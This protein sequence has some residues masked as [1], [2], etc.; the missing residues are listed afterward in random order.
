[1][2]R[3]TLLASTLALLI[4]GSATFAIAQDTNAPPPAGT[5]AGPGAPHGMKGPHGHHGHG[6]RGMRGGPGKF[7][8]G[9]GVIS[10]LHDLERLYLVSGR[11]KELPSLYNQV[12]S[13]SQNP[14]V[15]E[16][17]YHQLARAQAQPTNVDAA[18][19]TLRKSLDENLANETKRHAEREQMR[20]RWQQRAAAAPTAPAAK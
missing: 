10:D 8:P 2:Q 9:M 13:K 20:A 19:A 12:L 18:I 16:Y 17:A 4:A 7:G 5:S 11:G 3:K 15:R 1:M 6:D 14:R